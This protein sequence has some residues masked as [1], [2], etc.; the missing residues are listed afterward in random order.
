MSNSSNVFT[1]ERLVRPSREEFERRFLATQT[2]V[3]ISGAMADW[4]ALDRWTNAYLRVKAGD[5]TIRVSVA[6]DKGV[7]F[8]DGKERILDYRPMK[9]AEYIDG[10][11]SGEC[12]DGRLYATVI[13]LRETLP[14]LADDIGYP[15]YFDREACSSAHIWYGPGSNRSP[16]HYDAS[17][18]FLT[19]IR[20]RKEVKLYPPREIHNLYPFPFHYA[21]SHVSRV[22]VSTPDSVRFPKYENATSAVVHIEPG[23]MLFIPLFWWHSV[24]GVDQNISANFW[25]TTPINDY[26]SYPTQVARGAANFAV[27]EL[28]KLIKQVKARK[29]AARTPSTVTPKEL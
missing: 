1:V 8:Y 9:L 26:L 23:D 17:H 29:S 16:L 27:V 25:W 7:H 20:G 22:D 6:H 15:P 24:F 12:T 28:R 4:P 11:E 3:V 21:A 5:R 13:P 18:N 10:L 2:P 19:Q 14:E